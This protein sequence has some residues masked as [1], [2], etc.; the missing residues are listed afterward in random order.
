MT[1]R[2]GSSAYG[3]DASSSIIATRRAYSTVRR[4]LSTERVEVR[5]GRGRYIPVGRVVRGKSG[6][7]LTSG[8]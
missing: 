7:T 2:G 8:I 5:N 4:G 6:P 1:R 3:R